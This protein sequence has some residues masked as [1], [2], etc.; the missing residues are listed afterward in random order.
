MMTSLPALDRMATLSHELWLLDISV[1]LQS[2]VLGILEHVR[3][4][5]VSP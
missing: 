4:E 5:T 1:Q 2:R 3:R